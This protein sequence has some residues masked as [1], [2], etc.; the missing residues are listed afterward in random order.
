ME[1]V[2]LDRS[3]LDQLDAYDLDLSDHNWDSDVPVEV[4]SHEVLELL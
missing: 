2:L 1:E 3:I 4:L